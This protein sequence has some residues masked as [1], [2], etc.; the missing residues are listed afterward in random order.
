MCRASI[1]LPDPLSPVIS[2]DESNRATRSA[3]V[4]TSRNDLLRTSTNE[5]CKPRS[6]CST[7]LRW[8]ASLEPLDDAAPFENTSHCCCVRLTPIEAEPGQYSAAMLQAD[9]L[10][11]V[12]AHL[13]KGMDIVENETPTMKM[14]TAIREIDD[15]FELKVFGFHRLTFL[16]AMIAF[17]YAIL[18]QNANICKI[19]IRPCKTST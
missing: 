16:Y 12:F 6:N 1:S 2:T 9:H 15:L 18:S 7:R 4:S 17:Q 10:N 19:I 13:S 14:Q 8:R 11:E 5:P 3:N